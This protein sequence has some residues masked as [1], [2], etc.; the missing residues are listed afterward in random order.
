MNI[1][2]HG[3]RG[4]RGRRPENTLA[5]VEYAL[6]NAVDGVEVDLRITADDIIVL[7]HDLWLNPATT[8]DSKGKWIND[9][10]EIP[11]RDLRLNELRQY[12]VGR[13]KPGTQY[14]AK[15][16]RQ[17]PADGAQVPTLDEYVELIRRRGKTDTILNLELKGNPP[18]PALAPA[19]EHYV[20]LLLNKLEQLQLS[21]HVFLQSFDWRLIH[22]IKQQRPDLKTGLLT[23]LQP[24]KPSHKT[25]PRQF[26]LAGTPP[27]SIPATDWHLHYASPPEMVA[28]NGGDVWSSNHLD[29]SEPWIREAHA[30]GLEVYAWTVNEESDIEKMA[31]WGVD[32]ITTDYPERCRGLI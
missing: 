10:I 28:K 11:I 5:A 13:I 9:K 29:L 31:G 16:P 21:E 2:I 1:K 4:A 24:T 6:E 15:F 3:H 17:T 7:H 12:D 27:I 25:P 14:A 30:L 26:H 22:P 23:N 32:A 8:R 20:S 18:Q 19:P